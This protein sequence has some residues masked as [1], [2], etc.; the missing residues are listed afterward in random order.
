MKNGK[1]LPLPL[2][3]GIYG[4]IKDLKV[5]DFGIVSDDFIEIKP[6]FEKQI[7]DTINPGDL[8]FY[9]SKNR[10]LRFYSFVK[11]SVR[12][13]IRGEKRKF[14]AYTLEGEPKVYKFSENLSKITLTKENRKEIVESIINAGLW[15]SFR[16]RPF[17]RVADPDTIPDK[18]FALLIDTRPFS[19]DV[20]TVLK[21]NEDFLKTGLKVISTLSGKGVFVIKQSGLNIDIDLTDTSTIDVSG[22]HPIGLIGTHINKLYPLNRK[23]KVWYIDYQDIIKIGKLFKENL[24]DN[25]KVLSFAGESI[26]PTLYRMFEHSSVDRIVNFEDGKRIIAGS[27]L[28]GRKMTKEISFIH[29]YI[30]IVSTIKEVN[31]RSFMGW[32]MPGLKRFSVKNVFLSKLVK[33]QIEFNTSL[34][35]SFRPMVPVGSYEKVCML[36]LPITYFLRTLLVGDVEMAE[37]LGVLDLGEEDMSVFTFVCVGKYDYGVYLRQ[38]LNEIEGEM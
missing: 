4:E 7:N 8:L 33:T 32:L 38:I 12:E 17:D 20:K 6:K 14:L 23:R 2:I 10:G 3:K 19:P 28:Y 25:T 11:G 35:G 24:V 34:N 27:P 13:I 36:D 5:E 26:T 18:I 29:R 16:Q 15:V 21:G 9:D 22:N 37:K 31:E 30:N 1:G